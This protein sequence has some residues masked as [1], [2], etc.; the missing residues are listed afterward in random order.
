MFCWK[1]GWD[2]SHTYTPWNKVTYQFTN[3]R[4]RFPTAGNWFHTQKN[5][6]NEHSMTFIDHQYVFSILLVDRRSQEF[7]WGTVPWI[8]HLIETSFPYGLWE[9]IVAKYCVVKV[10]DQTLNLPCLNLSVWY[11]LC[12]CTTY[13][14]KRL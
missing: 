4:W 14:S 7:S 5:R 11:L 2:R 10:E 3:G 9:S 1:K 12:L 6:F 8:T 13:Q